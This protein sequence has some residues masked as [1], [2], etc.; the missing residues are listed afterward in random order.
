MIFKNFHLLLLVRVILLTCLITYCLLQIFAEHAGLASLAG[1]VVLA[2]I[3][4]LFHYIA[5]R[6]RHVNDFFEAVKYRDFNRHYLTENK[7]SDLRRLYSGFNLVNETV[8]NIQAERETQY[9]YLQK[10]L[11]MVETGIMA[12]DIDSGE[13]LWMN[14]AF[15]NALDLPFFKNVSFVLTRNPQAHSSLFEGTF[16]Q[17][18]QVNVPVRNETVSLLAS[19]SLFVFE[20]QSCKLL[21]VH[22]IEDTVNRTEAEAWKKLLSVMTHEIMNS[23]APISSLAGTLRKQVELHRQSPE[24]IML[25]AEDLDDGLSSIESRSEGLMRFAKTYRSLNKVVSLN[26]EKINVQQLFH[27]LE[28]LMQPSAG[29]VELTF[30]VE[31]SKLELK[32]DAYLIEQVL[33]NLILNAIQACRQAD[34]A[35]VVI[36]AMEKEEDKIYIQVA[37]NGPGMPEEVMEKAFI[38]FF[39]TKKTGS[40]IGLSL[41]KQI[42]TLHSGKIYIQSAESKG[43]SINLVFG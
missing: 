25:D 41:C 32:A 15:H 23:I 42:M 37:D 14:E 18:T 26:L 19:S 17:P 22:N 9:L 4:E 39:T 6:F 12:Y 36:S 7:V 40:G 11:E 16:A 1:V 3:A 38:P 27:S 8:R 34:Q 21:V 30:K 2:S 5:R 31:N 24:Q 35:R 10:I 13:V 20:Q 43:T 33:I 29:Q 28:R